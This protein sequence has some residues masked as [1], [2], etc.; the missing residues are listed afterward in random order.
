MKNCKE[1]GNVLIYILIAVALLAALTFA[2]SGDERGQQTN[3]IDSARAKLLATDMIK[4]TVSAEQA[5]FMMTQFGKNF[6]D[7]EFDIPPL[8][9]I[10]DQIYHPSGGGLQIF[11]T[12]D[13]HFDGNG[14]TGW[15][16]QGN[17]SVGW[18][19]TSAT[20]LIYTFINVNDQVCEQIN[21]QLI[22][23]TTI[24]TSTIDF[25]D[26]FTE[27]ATDDPFIASECTDCEGVKSLCI[28]DGT[29]NAFY[30]TVGM[31]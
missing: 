25:E 23:N 17:T 13:N 16:W 5:V 19:G 22:G 14:T 15:E 29:T 7:I 12:N 26:V 1:N 8:T 2:I 28:T 10:G 20:D 18:S 9:N 11:S 27:S 6:D 24:P 31:R 4:H 21:N 30:T 3:Q